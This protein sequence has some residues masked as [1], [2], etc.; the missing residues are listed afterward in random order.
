M[1]GVFFNDCELNMLDD[2]RPRPKEL[3]IFGAGTM[4]REVLARLGR[5]GYRVQAFLDNNRRLWTETVAGLPV[6]D[7]AT[8]RGNAG[9]TV[10]LAS[11]LADEMREH[12]RSLEISDVVS[13]SEAV[14]RFHL[15]HAFTQIEEDAMPGLGVWDDEDSI[16]TY[17]SLLR[18]R[19]TLDLAQLPSPA[20]CLYFTDSVATPDNLRA[21][22]DCGAFDGDTYREFKRVTNGGYDRYYGFEP[23]PVLYGILEKVVAGD[24]RAVLFKCGLGETAGEA[25]FHA[26]G[27]G[28]SNI[29][30]GGS[31]R[32]RVDSLDNV[33][34]N[35]PISMIKMDI[36][37]AEMAALAGAEKIIRQQRP[38]LA[39]SCYHQL[40]HLW[41]IPL[42]IRALDVGYRL[43]LLHHGT[44]YSDSVCY[45]IPG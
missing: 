20:P 18:F 36:E 15:T 14:R 19:G 44:S 6:V 9:I 34:A 5:A 45:G 21:F 35:R 10:I 16:L 30:E 23:E 41:R 22:V 33:L 28:H 12:C 8:M 32:I 29:E 42:W 39:I 1:S 11:L 26:L 24:S 37:G 31:L 4:G 2:L 7:P 13:M 25:N 38:L 27:S 3:Y 17:R 43:R 40:D